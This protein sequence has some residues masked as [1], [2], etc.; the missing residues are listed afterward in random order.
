MLNETLLKKNVLSQKLLVTSLFLTLGLFHLFI[1]I[2]NHYYYRTFAFDYGVYSFAFYDFAH[3]RI[4]ACPV[5]LTPFPVTFLQ[6]HFS[7]TLLIL[8]PLYWVFAPVFGTYSLLIIQWLFILLGAGFTYK[9]VLLKTQKLWMAASATVYFFVLYSRFSAYQSDC[10]LVTMGSALVPVFLYAFEARRTVL[11]IT[12]FSFLILNREDFSLGLA[13]L[14]LLLAWLHRKDKPQKRKALLLSLISIICFI[15]IFK[16]LIPLLENE[17]KKFSLF[18]YS[19]L[20]KT[21]YEAFLFLLSHPLKTCTMLFANHT[22]KESGDGIKMAFYL[23]YF[24]SGGFMLF[25]RP[26]YLIAFIPLVTKKMFNDDVMRW[27]HE[28]YHGVE[29]ASLM[30]VVVFSI[31]AEIK[32]GWIKKTLV[33][34]ILTLTV[35]VTIYGIRQSNKTYFGFSKFNIL[36][37]GFYEPDYDIKSIQKAMQT[38][39]DSSAVS[40]SGRLIPH[41][42]FRQKIYYFPR[43]DDAEYV[44]IS[45]T[46]HTYPLSE[47]QYALEVEKIMKNPEWS[48]VADKNG[49]LMLHKTPQNRFIGNEK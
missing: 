13:F 21:P 15:L 44:C 35:G 23:V 1:V 10:N 45:K 24:I 32:R 26:A 6:D 41:M 17:D 29:V 34:L 27:S 38:I 14:C 4:S 16:F 20:G 33:F 31:L 30:P 40:A 3:F 18:N 39:P 49:F 42:A 22:A 8:S 2:V 5:Y 46:G 36:S 48:V 37:P 11:L 43:I 9:F 19:A 25:Y 28:L 12:T 47:Q 7:F